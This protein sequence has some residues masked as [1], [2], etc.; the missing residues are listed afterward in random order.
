MPSLA[1]QGAFSCP[2]GC[3]LLPS[4]V[5]SL[6]LQGSFSCPPGCL[7]LPSRVPS[8]A[9]QGALQDEMVL[10]RVMWPNQDSFCCLTVANKGSYFNSNLI[11]LLCSFCVRSRVHFRCI[12]LN[13]TIHFQLTYLKGTDMVLGFSHIFLALAGVCRIYISLISRAVSVFV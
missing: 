11:H 7:L 8:L 9:L 1:L 5:P 10:C 4:R 6:A 12:C 13:G 2:P 3:L